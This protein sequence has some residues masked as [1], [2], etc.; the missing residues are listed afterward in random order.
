[1]TMPRKGSTK[2]ATA[3]APAASGTVDQDAQVAAAKAE[4]A[5]LERERLEAAQRYQ[6][7][8]KVANEAT[9]EPSAPD[10]AAKPEAPRF[11]SFVA[12]K[13]RNLRQ[14]VKAGEL[15]QVRDPNSPTGWRDA[16]RK[17]TGPNSDVFVE[18]RSG[19]L[20]T[21]DPDVI[22]WC[23]AHPKIC[24]DA[25]DPET[26]V[27]ANLV[28]AQTW[29]ARQDPTLSPGMDVDAFMKGD[30]SAMRGPQADLIAHAQRATELANKQ[31]G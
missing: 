15:N 2:T 17:A 7:Q 29:T 28:N 11:R 30:R 13:E 12:P 22:A 6:D 24:R 25:A 23:E 3:P 9:E 21:D 1:M 8:L 10:P 27:W 14:L 16:G 19:S 20:T 26:V 31:G 5:R 4:Q 18:F